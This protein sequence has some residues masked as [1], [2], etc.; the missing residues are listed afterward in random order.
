[1]VIPVPTAFHDTQ[2]RVFEAVY[3]EYYP[4]LLAFVCKRVG[5]V[6]TAQDIVQSVFLSC[7]R[8]WDKYDLQRGGVGT[9]LYCIA[10][11]KVKNHYRD[12]KDSVSIDALALEGGQEIADQLA[13]CHFEML[14]NRDALARALECLPQR[15]RDVVILSYFGEYTD[16]EVAEYM[17]LSHGNVRAILSRSRKLLAQHLKQDGFMEEE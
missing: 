15:N 6:E 8:N 17:N 13:R 9:W 3:A 2:Q 7:Y 5:N 14:E 16:Q 4:K 11:N 1:M 10:R 12:Q